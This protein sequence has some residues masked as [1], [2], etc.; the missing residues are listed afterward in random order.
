M[1]GENVTANPT[2]VSSSSSNKNFT[3]L[4]YCY[5]CMIKCDLGD[6]QI[7]QQI[8]IFKSELSIL[9]RRNV[10]SCGTLGRATEIEV[11]H[12][13]LNLDKLVEK[14]VYHIDVRFTPELPE[15]LLRYIIL[16]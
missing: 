9:K 11:N 8:A 15:R 10:K 16:F 12:L 4:Y 6:Q 1:I 5:T 14:T 2:P 7:Q 3:S 13:P